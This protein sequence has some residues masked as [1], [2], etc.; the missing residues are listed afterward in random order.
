MA[1]GDVFSVPPIPDL[2]YVDTGMY[3][4]TEYG[5]VYI[6]DAERPAIVDTGTGL[7]Y[8]R[9]LDALA[10]VGI[11]PADLEVIALTHIHLDHAGG[12]GYLLEECPNATVEVYERGADF[13]RDP[14][15][16]VAGTKAAVGDEWQYYA[17]PKPIPEDRLHEFA[18]GETIDLGD[19]Q[20]VAHAAH[21]HAFHQVVFEEP[22]AG[23]VF[24]ADAAGIYVPASDEVRPTSPPSDFDLEGVI[25]DAHVID[26]LDPQVLC[27]GH[28]GATRADDRLREYVNVITEWVG[29]VEEKRAELDDDEAV[30]DYF[31]DAA[32]L[33]PSW[34]ERRSRAEG[35]MNAKGVLAYL[36]ERAAASEE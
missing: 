8:E 4:T 29:R 35:R 23:V 27:Y 21:G 32:P 22:A 9:V 11:A 17:D 14:E 30:L 34:G 24:T 33:T 13:V 20:L 26:A 25:A 1:A 3:E 12:A 10:E 7:T 28:F 31:A 36:D 18:A 2:H 19:R 16:L 5:T 15:G 6:L